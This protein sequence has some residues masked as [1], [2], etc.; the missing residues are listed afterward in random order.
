MKKRLFFII[1]FC[2]LNFAFC[3]IPFHSHA[4][5]RWTISSITNP[6]PIE[7][8]DFTASCKNQSILVTWST[9]SETNNDYFTLE[10]SVDAYEWVTIATING[11]GNSNTLV[12][13]NYTDTN[14]YNDIVYYRLKQ[15]DIDGT[16]TYSGISAINCQNNLIEIINIY[17]NPVSDCFGYIIFSTEARE[18]FIYVTDAFGRVIINKR[19]NIAEGLNYKT[20]DVS[21]LAPAPYYLKIETA[22]GLYKDSKQILVK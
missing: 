11:M 20:L 13:Y 22:N 5:S 21:G 6:L 14:S 17:P 4:Q 9:A 8:I 16:C 3:I 18:I 12:N 15:T 10:R 19:E 1:A 2:I 7:L